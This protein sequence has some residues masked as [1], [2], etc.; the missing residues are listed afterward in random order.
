MNKLK[1]ATF[2]GT[3]PEL[4]R[5]SSVISLLDSS[6]SIEHILV[7]T[8][9]NYD[10]ELNEIFFEDL[11]IRKPDYF[12]DAAGKTAIET[13][14]HILIKSEKILLKE[15]PDFILLYGD[16]DS[17]LAGSIAASKIG[18]PILHVESGLR[19]FLRNQPEEINRLITDHV[20]HLCFAPTK[21]AVQNLLNEGIPKNKIF[22]SGDVLADCVR[23]FGNNEVSKCIPFLENNLKEKEYV[24]ATIHRSENTNNINILSSILSAL[25]KINSKVIFPIHPRTKKIISENNLKKFFPK[26]VFIEPMGYID[27]CN[28]EKNSLVIITDSGGIQKE[29][30]LHKVPCLTLREST[31]WKELIDFGWNKLADPSNEDEIIKMFEIQKSFSIEHDHP[32]FYGDGFSSTKII[33]FL[34]KNLYKKS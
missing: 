32:D 1:I 15:K 22:L 18:I 14:G 31:E 23:I 19:S 6:S 24:L 16:T 17:T 5:L 4:I 21:L 12:L 26:I 28:L 13:I 2:V 7:H 3:R 11:N 9:Q 27:M 25:N 33:N 29:A 20:S 30:Y 8:G 34:Q 10:Y